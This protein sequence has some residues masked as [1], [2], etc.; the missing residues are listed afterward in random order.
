MYTQRHSYCMSEEISHV[1]SSPYFSLLAALRVSVIFYK[2]LNN[3]Y[4]TCS[5][6]C[7]IL[8][9][10]I[11]RKGPSK[12]SELS[13][14]GVTAS[15]SHFHEEHSKFIS[16]NCNEMREKQRINNRPTLLSTWP[17]LCMYMIFA[18]KIW[19]YKRTKFL[20]VDNI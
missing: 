13:S 7:A 15:V 20:Q 18:D 17:G 9:N 2:L 19:N 12:N 16:A 5:V 3:W 1:L 10:R 11:R 6:I 4:V 14:T 8:P